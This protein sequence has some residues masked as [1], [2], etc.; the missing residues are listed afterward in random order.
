M[1]DSLTTTEWATIRKA[2][3]LL[4]ANGGVTIS[5]TG[6]PTPM[7]GYIVGGLVPEY[8]CLTPT[9]ENIAEFVAENIAR[10]RTPGCYLGL[11]R[12]SEAQRVHM[13][14]SQRYNDLGLA[15]YVGIRRGEIAIW[16][17]ANAKEIQL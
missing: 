1:T 15:T 6:E 16:D 2:H 5:L 9:W 11:W 17:V 14:V 4:D 3:S 13:D 10:L 7:S 8:I 12:D